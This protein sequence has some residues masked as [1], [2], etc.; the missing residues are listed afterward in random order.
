VT[1]VTISEEAPMRLEDINLLDR[2]VFT[3]GVPHEWVH[4]SA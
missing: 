2:D 4:L 3:K 1:P